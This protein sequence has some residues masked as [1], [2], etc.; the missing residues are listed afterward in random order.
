MP[1]VQQQK[2][3]QPTP[4]NTRKIILATNV[5]ET[6]LTISG[7]RYV[8]DTGMAKVRAFNSKMGTLKILKS[9][10]QF[11]TGFVLHTGL[12]SLAVIPI[13]K[14]SARQRTGRAGREVDISVH[15]TLTLDLSLIY[16]LKGTRCLLSPIYSRWF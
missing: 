14:A 5:A 2:V 6:S 16:L 7:I 13:S 8:I 10:G 15:G 1:A 9:N 3:F 12:E 4:P 11:L